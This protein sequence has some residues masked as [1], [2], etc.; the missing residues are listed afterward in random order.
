[1]RRL[2]MTK[3][4]AL[5]AAVAFAA[6]M[7]PASAAPAGAP[8]TPAR[9][10]A[11]PPRDTVLVDCFAKPQVRP[12]D[13]VLAC[14]DG[15]SRLA[16]LRWTHWDTT[17]A[18]AK[19]VNWLNDCEPYCA[20]GTFRSYPVVVRLDQ[21]QSW[22]GHPPQQRYDRMTLTYTGDRP[23]RSARTVTYALWD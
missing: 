4:A 9:A 23:E 17:S 6:A 13:F 16:A 2:A 20:A 21:T 15:N 5:C 8:A 22:K 14:G 10:V 19:G 1:M 7:G 3:A 18:R 11:Q 12:A